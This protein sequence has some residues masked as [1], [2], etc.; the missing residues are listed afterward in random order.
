MTSRRL[1]AHVVRHGDLKAF[2][3]GHEF[4]VVAPSLDD[5]AVLLRGEFRRERLRSGL[6]LHTADT[7][8]LYDL[9][10]CSVQEAGL[11]LSLFLDGGVTIWQGDRAFQMGRTTGDHGAIEAVMISRAQRETFRRQSM[12]GTHVRKVNIT[13]LPHWLEE[14][15]LDAV[16]DHRHAHAFSRT[17]LAAVRWRSSPRLLSLA[18]QMLAPPA[19]APMLRKLYCESRAIDL[20]TEALQVVAQSDQETDTPLRPRDLQRVRAV[21][22]FIEAHLDDAVTLAAL[23]RHAG[24]SVSSLQRVFRAAQ[25]TTVVDYVRSRKLRRARE[26]LERDG[27]SVNEV[28]F[29]AGYASPANFATAFKRAFGVPPRNFRARV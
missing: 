17:H 9:E 22:D 18:E 25:G 4:R 8:D 2:A 27:L 12:R 16:A 15:G 3:A 7:T 14:S 23:A 10:T 1:P 28:A 21:R 24:M 5:H 6:I 20:I 26:A 11:T 13:V 29:L 19:F